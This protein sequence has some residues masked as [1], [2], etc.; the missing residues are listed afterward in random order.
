MRRGPDRIV[1]G[2]AVLAALWSMV[3]LVALRFLRGNR[4]M[5]GVDGPFAA[6]QLFYL[7][8]IRESGDHILVRNLYDGSTQNAWFIHP[9]FLASGALWRAGMPLV[10]SYQLWKPI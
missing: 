2:V 5:V 1:M 6:D 8:W 3:D 7:S 9:M 4:V 10:L